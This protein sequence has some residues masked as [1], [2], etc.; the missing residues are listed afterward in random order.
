MKLVYCEDQVL[1]GNCLTLQLCSSWAAL[2]AS[3][4]KQNQKNLDKTL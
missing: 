2:L 1:I 3:V 4:E